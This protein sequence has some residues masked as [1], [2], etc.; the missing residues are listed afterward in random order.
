MNTRLF[1]CGL[2]L[3]A[4]AF[5][6]PLPA[7]AAYIW[8]EGENPTVNKMNR[9]PW[10][11]DQVKRQAF[12]G[13]D[14]ISNFSQEKEGEAEYRFTAQQAGEYEFWVR[15]NPLMAKLYFTLNGAAETLI[16]LNREKRDELNVA[17]DNKPDL[18][19]L[20]WSKVGTLALRQGANTIRFRM[21]SENNHHGY[22]DC[23]V[24]STEPFQPR[25]AIKPDQMAAETKRL[26]EENQGWFPFD[27]K[28]D[29]FAENAALDLRFLNEKFAGEHG[30]IG[31][32]DGEFIHTGNGEPLR[33]WAVNG[34]PHELKGA[35]LQK[36]ARLLAKHG[37]NLVRI[38]GGYFDKD[39]EVDVA[40]VRHGLEIVEAMKKEGIYSHFSIFFPLWLDPKP[41]TPWLQGYNGKMHSFAALMFNPAFQ[42]QY[43]KWWT[44]LLTTP[45]PATGKLLVEE[46]ALA[47]LEM[48]NEDS[49]FFWTFGESNIPDPQLRILEAMFGDWLKKKYGS[50]DAL[51]KWNN[52]K[53]KRD[54]PAEGR[55]GFRPLWN[56][57]N[58]R[59]A[60][61][62]DT[63]AFLLE[64]QTKF[65]AETRDFLRKL[66][67]KGPITASNWTTAS[68]EYFG[69]LE[70]LS[71]TVGDFIDRHGYF[72]CN[73]KGDNA[74]WSVQNNHT[75]SDRSAYRFDN[76]TPGKPKVFFH[77]AMDPHYNGLPSMISETTWCRP[78]R[79]RSEAPLYLAGYGA[80]QHSDAIVHFAL[81]SGTWAVKPGFFMQPWT[82][83]T[84]AMMGQFPAA[85]LIY[86]RGFVAPGAVVAEVNLNKDDLLHLKGTPLP[87]DAGLDELRLKD[88]PQGVDLKP[89]Q[90]LNPLLHYVGRADVK[91][92]A[93]PGAVK[94]TDLKPYLDTAAQ[95]V[96]STTGELKLDYGKGVLTLNAPKAQGIS[97]LIKTAGRVETKDLA[98]TSDMDLGHIIAVPLDDQPLAVSGKILLQVMS[99]EKE[100]NQR[101][102]AASANVKRLLSIGTDPWMVKEFKGSVAFKRADAA[103]LKATALDFNGYPC[104]QRWHRLGPQASTAH[105]LL[106]H[107]QIT[108]P[109]RRCANMRL[110]E[111][112]LSSKLPA[113]RRANRPSAAFFGLAGLALVLLLAACKQEG[114]TAA[115]VAVKLSLAQIKALEQ[116]A[117]AGDATEKYNLGKK[118]RDGDVVPQNLTNAAI[119]FRKAAAAGHAKAQYHLGLACQ[120]GEGVAKNVA[121]AAKW[122]ALAA[123]Q[124]HSKAQ[125]RIGLMCWN[126]EGVAK[127]L[128]EAHKWLSLA[129]ANGEHK[130]AKG[131]KKLELSMSLQQIAEAKKLVA[132]FAPKKALKKASKETNPPSATK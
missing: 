94:L 130:A 78:N 49:F 16:D 28:P 42:A 59:S 77:P 10:W 119:W 37:V 51:A 11:Y 44:A 123:E 85:A 95:T 102:E 53:A 93:T 47:S 30:F 128:V 101:T 80:L 48:Q 127:D 116:S 81:D 22:L 3:A 121:E 131:V 73:H 62:Q 86:R 38:H 88:V 87:Q 98:I 33:F 8:I 79:W 125:E 106:S 114:S 31:V 109:Q 20:A 126:G 124:D 32:K 122:Y 13:G 58:E 34:P 12:S 129:A 6:A 92:V 23:F 43:R 68:P 18:R 24:F 90:R 17:A 82:L 104:R 14:F 105:A 103:Q 35:E 29:A 63:A 4:S 61:D 41:G 115:P 19:F 74:G 57:F 100:S 36:C 111:A 97:G 96:T 7:Q 120:E 84:P 91:F 132:A 2:S 67:F 54:A 25:G 69:P 50:L 107:Q 40:K 118:Y 52:Q 89:G 9:H 15:A 60:R 99:E 64:V 39:G 45:S 71:Y 27:P 1:C 117:E 83:M 110:E 112:S 75:W 26:A 21:A 5:L 65:Y 76:E 108:A 46:P 113:M 66:G 55:I 56:M 72:E 70:K